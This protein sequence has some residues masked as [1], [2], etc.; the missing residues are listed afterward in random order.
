MAI[1]KK[2]IKL[3]KDDLIS[4]VCEKY[5]LRESDAEFTLELIAEERM[6]QPS[7]FG[8]ITITGSEIPQTGEKQSTISTLD[9]L[10]KDEEMQPDFD[11]NN[12]KMQPVST[13]ALLKTNDDP[14]FGNIP[15]QFKNEKND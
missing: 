7:E 2:L 1:I 4:L 3:S 11:I 8:S 6:S 15:S 12:V 14:N 5:K 13:N 10:F 9:M